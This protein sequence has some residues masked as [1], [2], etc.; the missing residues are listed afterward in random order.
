MTVFRGET[1]GKFVSGNGCFIAPDDS[2]VIVITND[3]YVAAYDPYGGANSLK[4]EI[5]TMG[6]VSQTSVCTGGVAF[7]MAADPPYLVYMADDFNAG[8]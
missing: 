2:A 4:W 3:C 1:P 5:M 8:T 6:I 7:N